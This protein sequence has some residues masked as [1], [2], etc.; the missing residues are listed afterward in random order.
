[1][2]YRYRS[3][4]FFSGSQHSA[5]TIFGCLRVRSA[6]E[7]PAFDLTGTVGGT[8]GCLGEDGC[9]GGLSLMVHMFMKYHFCQLQPTG[10]YSIHD[11]FT[12]IH[13]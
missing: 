12:S 5:A 1:M 9:C 6:E 13:P 10:A 2:D 7:H 11:V 3:L 4:R 8:P